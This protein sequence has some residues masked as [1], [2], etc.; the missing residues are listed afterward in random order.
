MNTHPSTPSFI[1]KITA[2]DPARWRK[3][4]VDLARTVGADNVIHTHHR[5]DYREGF[6]RVRTGTR[7]AARAEKTPP[8][9]H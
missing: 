3:C 4:V 6:V 1:I 9:L 5:T 2:D 7:R 8:T